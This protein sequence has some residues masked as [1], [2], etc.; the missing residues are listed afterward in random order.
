[1]ALFTNVIFLFVIFCTM[2]ANLARSSCAS[3]P[4]SHQMLDE[5]LLESK[6]SH[7]RFSYTFFQSLNKKPQ[8][9][10]KEN[11]CSSKTSSL[12]QKLWCLLHDLEDERE[13]TFDQVEWERIKNNIEAT[14]G[15]RITNEDQPDVFIIPNFLT[16]MQCEELVKVQKEISNNIS[17]RKHWKFST[18]RQM[19]KAI[20]KASLSP[21]DYN[22]SMNANEECDGGTLEG[23]KINRKLRKVLK[24]SSSVLVPRGESHEV[25][26]LEKYINNVLGLPKTNAYHTQLVK[27]QTQSE[28]KAHTDCHH[29]SNDRMA[30]I[31]IYLT[32]VDKVR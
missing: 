15:Q 6:R 12:L 23:V 25:D 7:Y 20:H 24:I 18:T 17:T 1:M 2:G 26:A 28:Y 11:S 9:E 4:K 3:E 8:C 22:V 10:T 14:H 27:Y 29:I 32:D 30:T 13:C 16:P 19:L 31:I 5:I 21:D